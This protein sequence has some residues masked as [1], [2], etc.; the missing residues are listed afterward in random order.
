M[1]ITTNPNKFYTVIGANSGILFGLEPIFQTVDEAAAA[2]ARE[3]NKK[4]KEHG[5]KR[6]VKKLS[7]Y[8]G[9]T[10]CFKPNIIWDYK[11][12]AHNRF[13]KKHTQN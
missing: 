12:I 7:C 10:L 4:L 8:D 11:I 2:V 1:S 6:R 5:V 9:Y 3:V 13:T